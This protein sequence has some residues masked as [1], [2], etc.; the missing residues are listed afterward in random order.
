MGTYPDRV[1]IVC[2]DYG[3]RKL[4]LREC[5]D[6]QGFPDNFRFPNSITVGDAYKQIGNSVCVPVVKRIAGQIRKALDCSS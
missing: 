2:D 3:I 4:T 6:F 1:P 5:L